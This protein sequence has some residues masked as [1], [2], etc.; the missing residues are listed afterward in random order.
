MASKWGTS[1]HQMKNASK[2]KIESLGDDEKKAVESLRAA[3]G[4]AGYED[5][6]DIFLLRF[7]EN[8]AYDAT[9][10]F[11]KL[12]VFLVEHTKMEDISAIPPHPPLS[13][14]YAHVLAHNS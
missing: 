5:V 8:K 1:A 2:L 9:A 10:A 4:K 3:V 13:F 7:L 12:T 11:E 6:P 14:L